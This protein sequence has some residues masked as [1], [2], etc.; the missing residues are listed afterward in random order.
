MLTDEQLSEFQRAPAR[1]YAEATIRK[2]RWVDR[3]WRAYCERIECD[4]YPVEK[5]AAIGFLRVLGEANGVA[6]KT[7]SQVIFPGLMRLHESHTGGPMD[8]IIKRT[9]SRIVRDLPGGHHMERDPFLF[10]D[11][12]R[13]ISVLLT[14]GNRSARHFSMILVTLETGARASTIAD[15]RLCDILGVTRTRAGL[16][17]SLRYRTMKTG[18]VHEVTIEGSTTVESPLDSVF[19]LN[20]YIRQRYQLELSLWNDYVSR[21]VVSSSRDERLLGWAAGSLGIVFRNMFTAAGYERYMFSF[22]SFRKGCLANHI[23]LSRSYDDAMTSSAI[24]ANWARN[25]RVQRQYAN[26]VILR[27]RIVSRLDQSVEPALTTVNAFHRTNFRDDLANQPM[28]QGSVRH[29]TEIRDAIRRL[30]L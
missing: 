27:T 4:P 8:S 3:L 26:P 15:V 14:S 9:I 17:V 16:P 7:I 12:N 2:D 11:A 6:R 10:C 1:L 20:E 22:H 21:G 24:T 29:S 13:V 18:G 5:D 25:G 19:W 28:L 30:L 23:V